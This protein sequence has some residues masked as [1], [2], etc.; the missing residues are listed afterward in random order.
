VGQLFHTFPVVLRGG[1]FI[2][3]QGGGHIRTG[4]YPE[5]DRRLFTRCIIEGPAILTV[6]GTLKEPV[7][8][9]DLCPKGA[10][11]YCNQP[12]NVGEEVEVELS[13]FFDKVI[14]KKAKVVWCTEAEKG[15]WRMGLNFGNDLLEVGK[16]SSRNLNV[17]YKQRMSSL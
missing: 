1:E 9:I 4:N 2:S 3:E 12:L 6:K 5:G 10:G 7:I 11:I 14:H 15:S 17:A 13:C 8:V 16:I